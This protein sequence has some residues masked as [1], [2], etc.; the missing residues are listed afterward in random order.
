MDRRSG[1]L[2]SVEW[3][4]C[5][6]GF[7]H[8]D[9]RPRKTKLTML[10]NKILQHLKSVSHN[11]STLIY[12]RKQTLSRTQE[13]LAEQYGKYQ[14]STEKVFRVAYN[15]AK[16]N[17][18][19]T[20]LPQHVDCYQSNGVDMGRVL[21]SDMSCANIINSIASDMRSNLVQSILKSGSKITV[22]VDESTTVSGKSSLVIHLRSCIN[23][24]PTTLFL[25][26]LHL[27]SADAKSIVDAIIST[28]NSHGFSRDWLKEN[29]I[30]F[31]SD[32]ASVMT[33]NKSGVGVLLLEMFPNLL[34][35]HCANHRLELAV[36][37]AVSEVAGSNPF[38]IFVDNLYS[39]YSKS[40]KLQQEL[41][42]CAASLGTQLL[43][44]GKVLDT[45]WAA[46]S[47]RTVKAVWMSFNPLVDHFMKK[48][49]EAKFQ[50]LLKSLTSINF[51]LNLAI[52]YDA[53]EEI[54]NL[55]LLLQGRDM[56]LVRAH[57]LIDQSIKAMHGMA[58]K[59]GKFQQQA[60]E[61]VE[62]GEFKGVKFSEA[63]VTAINPGQFF[64]SLENS[65]KA[66]MLTI[67]SRR[68]EKAAVAAQNSAEYTDLLGQIS[69]LDFSTWPL[70]YDDIPNFGENEIAELCGRFKLE[71]AEA[72]RGFKLF[73][74]VGGKEMNPS[75]QA[76]KIV[77]GSIP[78]STAECERAFSLMNTI[79]SEKRNRLELDNVSSLMFI[80][81]V[82]P[83]I[84][85][86]KPALYVKNW[87][88]RGNHGASD[89][90][91][92][93]RKKPDISQD[94]YAHVYELL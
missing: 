51:I 8:G 17:R 27:L 18:P 40:P 16:M 55:S 68:G 88:R 62:E 36:H 20:D 5:N 92:E 84:T 11:S 38:K 41:K 50:G 37:D 28:L 94:Y 60:L 67:R 9:K 70:N 2:P 44:I 49:N 78:V 43:K 69:L 7:T 72:V 26:I 24:K 31:T 86:F 22:L 29:F 25:D 58:I 93:K 82:G 39:L 4:S 48:R 45:R 61:A 71:C 47:L 23:N 63:R 30:C 6:V 33:G 32:G 73:R 83:P 87:L 90:Q 85:A 14:N 59:P 81:V 19:Y 77:V 10:R 13:Q 91:C 64:T 53:L 46:S 79:I 35:W 74:A 42:E 34:L 76:L 75:L 12:E 54:S 89:T 15:I 57:K 52:F 1:V 56:S 80:S 21:H 66:R 3:V 65:L